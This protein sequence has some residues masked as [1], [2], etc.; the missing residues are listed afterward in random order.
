MLE[1]AKK[2]TLKFRKRFS[3][4]YFLTIIEINFIVEHKHL[5]TRVAQK[6]KLGKPTSKGLRN[7]FIFFLITNFNKTSI[8]VKV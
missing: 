8:T 3:F 1:T 2:K 6:V 4:V 7:I 5:P